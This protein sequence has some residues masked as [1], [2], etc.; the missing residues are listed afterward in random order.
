M[1][2][3]ADKIVG[4]S[5][6]DPSGWTKLDKRPPAFRIMDANGKT[7]QL[8]DLKGKVTLVNVWATWCGPCRE[9]LPN[10]QSSSIRVH[11]RKDLAVITL[12]TDENPGMPRQ[13][14]RESN[15]TFPVLPANE[16]VSRVVPTVPSNWIQEGRVTA[17]ACVVRRWKRP[18]GR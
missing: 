7:W 18:V 6:P 17:G 8:S 13:F 1:N 2:R 14:L 15:Y 9:E 11:E 16:Y 10:L 12:N 3:L 4:R 5:W